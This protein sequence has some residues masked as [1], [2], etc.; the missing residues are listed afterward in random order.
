MKS[1]LD[2]STS[3]LH[4]ELVDMLAR[5]KDPNVRPLSQKVALAKY[6]CFKAEATHRNTSARERRTARLARGW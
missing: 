5:S 6:H 2:M 1:P 3:E 4:A